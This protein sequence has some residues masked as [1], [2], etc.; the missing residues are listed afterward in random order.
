MEN[1]CKMT[2][3][4]PSAPGKSFVDAPAEREFWLSALRIAATRS[5]LETNI[6]ESLYSSFRQ[7]R[8]SANQVCLRLEKEGLLDR[9][10]GPQ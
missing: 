3:P 8:L 4:A 9:V 2:L 6:F 10:G 7:N 1:F 5:R